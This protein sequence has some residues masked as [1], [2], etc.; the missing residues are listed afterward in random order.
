VVATA[1]FQ[2]HEGVPAQDVLI[3]LSLRASD[4]NFEEVPATVGHSGTVKIR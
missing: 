3:T 2:V 4:E 1:E